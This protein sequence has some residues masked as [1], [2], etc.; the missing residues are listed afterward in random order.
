LASKSKR[1]TP[2]NATMADVLRKA[3]EDSGQSVYAIAKAAN[4]PQPV[5]HRF[6]SGERDLTLATANKLVVYFGFELKPKN[7]RGK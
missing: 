6:Y 5:L 1:T 2:Q 7:Q 4:I 3:I